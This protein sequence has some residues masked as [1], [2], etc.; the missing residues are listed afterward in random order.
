MDNVEELLIEVRQ[1]RMRTA[2]ISDGRLVEMNVEDEG[3]PSLV[4]NIYLGRVEKIIDSLNACF[5]DLGLHS[6]GFLALAEVLPIGVEITLGET[7]SKHLCEGDKVCVQIQRDAFEGKGPKLT[8]RLRLVSRS[9]ILTPGD[10]A[11][12]I[13]HRISVSETRSHLKNLLCDLAWQEEG[14][15]ARTAAESATKEEI[16]AHVANL[17]K[18]Y[19][20]I[21][22]KLHKSVAPTLIH[23]QVDVVMLTLR[24]RTPGDVS[25]IVIDDIRAYS[26]AKKFLEKEA[27]ALLSRLTHHKGPQPLFLRE[28][29]ADDIDQA[30]GPSVALPS[31]GSV[32]IT[33][34]SALI[35]MDVNVA[36]TSKGKH[37][38]SVLMT[39]LEACAEIARQIR[40]RNLSGLLVVDFVS[41][42][43]RTSKNKVLAAFKQFVGKDPE[44]VFVAG[45]TRFG[46]VEMTRKRSKPSLRSILGRNCLKCEGSGLSLSARTIGFYALDRLR[47]EGLSCPPQ[48]LELRASKE[49]AACFGGQLEF[50]LNDLKAELGVKIKIVI[51]ADLEDEFFDIKPLTLSKGDLHD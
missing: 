45:F 40:L 31:G 12:K 51:D 6:S 20:N 14:F 4:G 1:G 35:A 48:G 29:L 38:R 10:T 26:K 3:H 50:A 46:L 28:T 23:G 16:T 11:I 34:T 13:S 47:V 27:P 33:E 7:I 25:K 5:V 22:A 49:V 36:G 19:L 17:R 37:E 39:N 21:K 18:E 42:K 43:S 41:M 2:L 30:L 9:V 15:I 24:D 32:I 44:Q 8:T